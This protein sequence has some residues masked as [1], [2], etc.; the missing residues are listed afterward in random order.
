[1]TRT[2]LL[3]NSS[4]SVSRPCTR[5]CSDHCEF[6]VPGEGSYLTCACRCSNRNYRQQWD[7]LAAAKTRILEFVWSPHLNLGVKLAAIKFAQRVVLVQTRGISD[8]RVRAITFSYTEP[9]ISTATKQKRPQPLHVSRGSSFYS[10]TSSRDR[11]DQAAR[12]DHHY[13]VQQR[14]RS[15]FRL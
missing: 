11:G 14:V 6:R 10:R 4:S 13:P 7:T 15:L 5:C 8:P 9:N 12:R 1:M 3:S 2:R